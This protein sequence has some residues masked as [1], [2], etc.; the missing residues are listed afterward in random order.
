MRHYMRMIALIVLCCLCTAQSAR[1]VTLEVGG[2]TV[3]LGMSRQEVVS[4][5]SSAGFK[6]LPAGEKDAILF[7]EQS[8]FVTHLTHFKNDRLTFADRE[9]YVPNSDLDAFQSTLA[10]LGSLADTNQ[11]SNC[12]IIHQPMTDPDMRTNRIFIVCGERSLLL[13][14][15]RTGKTVGY[16]VRERIGELSLG[17]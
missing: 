5:Y 7:V 9:W 6:Q 14:E 3:W 13:S 12:T 1:K 17:D 15:M 16:G 8:Q 4:R 2:A 11:L 10:A